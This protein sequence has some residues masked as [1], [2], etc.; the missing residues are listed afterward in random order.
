MKLFDIILEQRPRIEKSDEQ[1]KK[2]LESSP[3]ATGLTFDNAKFI[4]NPQQKKYQVT[5]YSCKLHPTWS[6]D[7]WS[8]V[9][10]V[11]DGRATCAECAKIKQR[12][13]LDKERLEKNE[14]IKKLAKKYG[15][16]FKEKEPL[17]Y[18]DGIS[19][20]IIEPK[21]KRPGEWTAQEIEDIA[22]NYTDFND[23]FN[24]EN[25]AYQKAVKMGI[26]N[27]IVAHMSYKRRN[28]SFEDLQKLA[29]PFKH[30]IDF[31]RNDPAAYRTAFDKGWLDKLKEWVP[32]GNKEKRMVYAYEFFDK[33]RKPLAVYVGLTLNEDRR[34]KEHRGEWVSR[35]GK[36]SPVYKYIIDN[37]IKPIY[38]VLSNGY[39]PYMDAIDME[40][41]YQNDYYKKDKYKDGSLVW[42]P[43]HSVKCGGLG[44]F[45]KWTEDK[46]KNEVLKYK[47]LKD[48]TKYSG[49]A[50][51]A[52]KR[53]GIYDDITKNLI[54]LRPKRVTESKLSLMGTL[55]ELGNDK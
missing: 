17:L 30:K 9:S 3:N 53:L 21:R 26:I 37:N 44:G 31:S 8:R 27:D 33:K 54:R 15:D 34:G 42:K 4:Y 1:L 40:C 14:L 35:S 38:K 25:A 24:K 49:G 46:L 41:Y 5:N 22:D 28:L 51:S 23:F 36:T 6:K 50:P 32:L 18:A 20:K 55:N 47:T 11:I 19:N 10:Q 7:G 12:N 45:I 29:K 48:F 2:D 13:R 52:A 16:Q 39:I 43:L